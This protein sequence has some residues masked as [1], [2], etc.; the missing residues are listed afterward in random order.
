MPLAALEF[1]LNSPW[2]GKRPVC[3]VLSV[4][5]NVGPR[6]KP[7]PAPP[8]RRQRNSL[9]SNGTPLTDLINAAAASG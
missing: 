2:F 3:N 4:F 9:W 5:L 1:R 8:T 7:S 6:F